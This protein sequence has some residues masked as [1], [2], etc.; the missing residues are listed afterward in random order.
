MVLLCRDRARGDRARAEIAALSGN[1]AIDLVVG[2][3]SVASQT[4]EAARALRQRYERI[5]VLVHNAGI[6]PTRLERTEEGLERGFVVNHLA[7]FRL[8]AALADR[9]GPGSRVVQVTAGLAIKG[10]VDLART[11]E[12]KD[13]D[14]FRTYADTKLCNLLCTSELARLWAARSVTVNAVHPGVVRTAL[15]DL[16]G[17]L[18]L[19]LK[20][21]KRRWDAPEVGALGPV[22]LATD[23]SLRGVTGRY[24]DRLVET[25]WPAPA[26]DPVLA[27]ALWDRSLEYGP[28]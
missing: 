20:W 10:R 3:L 7:P 24:H 27:R 9:L 16:S 18:G 15:G 25:P 2:D 23:P 12:G 14:R 8:N 28:G 11:P 19:L 21:F 17:P 1:P 4:R 26:D 5:D 13:F 6:W 22:R